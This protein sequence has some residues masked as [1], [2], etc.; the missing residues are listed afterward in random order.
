MARPVV[1]HEVNPA[2]NIV[3]TIMLPTIPLG[4]QY[5]CTLTGNAFAFEGMGS[6]STNGKVFMFGTFVHAYWV[7]ELL[8]DL[9]SIVQA[10]TTPLLAPLPF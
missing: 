7:T 3:R 2:G 6:L 4:N 5:A 10:A 9:H 1:V 8:V